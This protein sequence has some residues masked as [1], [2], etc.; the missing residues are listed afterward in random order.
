MDTPIKNLRDQ[1]KTAI[2]THLTKLPGKFSAGE[3]YG[4]SLY[5]DEDVSSLG[6]VANSEKDL[7]VDSADGMYA[8]Y[9][10]SVDEWK[11]WDDFG[12]FAGV[13]Q[14][15]KAIHQGPKKRFAKNSTAILDAALDVMQELEE[16][17]LFGPRSPERFV[18]VWVSDSQSKIIKKSAKALN[19]PAAYKTFAEL[20]EEEPAQAWNA[21]LGELVQA[22]QNRDNKRVRKLID[23]GADLNQTSG[24]W[25]PMLAAVAGNN[26][27][28]LK[29]L[30][31]AGASIDIRQPDGDTLVHRASGAN[32]KTLVSHGADVNATNAKGA[33]PL[34]YAARFGQLGS[35]RM[36]LE[37][38]ADRTLR[39]RDG[40]T[41][42]DRALENGNALVADLLKQ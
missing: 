23:S 25:T 16:Q 38:G 15:V 36:L 30:L 37:L 39:D 34:H 18:V 6:P 7:K 14:T 40:K 17:G 29:L 10:F 1:L 22:V 32:L 19:S 11:H 9:R 42:L 26:E 28:S 3:F 12:T 41:P 20:M 24:V 31:A 35:A 2:R 4:Y 8:V 13:N 21:G 5:T 33:T 27:A